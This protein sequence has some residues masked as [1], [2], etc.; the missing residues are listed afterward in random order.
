MFPHTPAF[1]CW[2]SSSVAASPTWA[3]GLNIVGGGVVSS[4]QKAPIAIHARCVRGGHW[5]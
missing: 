3:G 1:Y 2:S 5:D 4:F